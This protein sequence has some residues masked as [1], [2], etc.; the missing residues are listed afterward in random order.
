MHQL[1][2]GEGTNIVNVPLQVWRVT[3]DNRSDRTNAETIA[4][5]NYDKCTHHPTQAFVR[6]RTTLRLRPL[7]VL[8]L[9]LALLHEGVHALLLILGGEGRME[10]PLL[11]R[12]GV[13]QR[14]F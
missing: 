2:S 1:F 11:V 5:F 6:F 13:V 4:L 7:L 8:E 14:H 9:R 12:Q 3:A 10:G